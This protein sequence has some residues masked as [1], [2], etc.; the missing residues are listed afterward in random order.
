MIRI[1][2]DLSDYGGLELFQRTYVH[3]LGNNL[4]RRISG[5]GKT[6]GDPQGIMNVNGGKPDFDTGANLERCV[7][8]NVK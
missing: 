7:F 6:F 5:D 2:S 1:A 8:G 3:E 4:S